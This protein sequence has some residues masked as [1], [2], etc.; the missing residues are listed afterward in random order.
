MTIITYFSI[1]L[2]AV[3][4]LDNV[5]K[6]PAASYLTAGLDEFSKL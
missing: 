1:T 3:G 5:T 4:A 2:T 6:V